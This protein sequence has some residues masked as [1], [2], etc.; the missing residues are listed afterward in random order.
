MNNKGTDDDDSS[1]LPKREAKSKAILVWLFC[2]TE[3]PRNYIEKE[4][5]SG[6]A[7]IMFLRGNNLWKRIQY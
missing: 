5:F 6:N 1:R 7:P 2:S 3:L 4:L